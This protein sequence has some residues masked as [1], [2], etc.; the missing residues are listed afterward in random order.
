MDIYGLLG[1]PLGH[2]FSAG[3]FA[4]KFCMEGIQAE[5][6][7][8]EFDNISIA[9]NYLK[10]LK[11]LRGFNVTI[12]YKEL[13]IPFLHGISPEAKEIGAVNVVK[14]KRNKLGEAE[15]YG[16]NTDV[17]GFS[18]SIKKLINRQVHKKALVLGTGGA[19]KAVVYG[20]QRM[21][22]QTVNVSRRP[23][24]HRITY[25]EVT[26]PVI[27]EYKIIVNCTPLGMYPNVESAPNIPYNLLGNEHL[28][29]DLVYNPLKTAFMQKGEKSGAT[30][31]NG[32]EMLHLQADAA[33]DIWTDSTL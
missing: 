5:Y 26:A 13:I 32:L 29:F 30:V 2:S 22:V 7:N 6:R 12:P 10:Q 15:L 9:L 20:L 18:R 4:D 23:D 28:L 17:E 16:Y 1:Y 3:Y 33:W 19:S 24:E 31:M 27:N 11:D 25:G 21:G 8:F 14:I